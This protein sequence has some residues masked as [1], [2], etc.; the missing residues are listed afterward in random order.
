MEEE[1]K[2]DSQLVRSISPMELKYTDV[3]KLSVFVTGAGKILARKFTGL[4][5]EQQRHITKMIKRAR[6]MLLM[7]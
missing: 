3:D 4:S 7:K 2:V 1:T 5:S 6:N